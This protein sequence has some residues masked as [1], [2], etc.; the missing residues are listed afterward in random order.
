MKGKKEVRAGKIQFRVIEKDDRKILTGTPIVYNKNSED[1]GFIESIKPGASTEALKR[2]DPRLLYGHNSDTLLPLARKSAGTL[3]I[4]EDK[5][6]VHIEADPPD[7]QFARDMITSIERGDIQDMSFGFTI[8]DDKWETKDGRDHRTI[9][10]F[11]E[12]F[13]FSFVAFPAYPD[14]TVAMRSLEQ[15]KAD[16]AT[17]IRNGVIAKE[18]D[19]L[20]IFETEMRIKTGGLLKC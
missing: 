16:D 15:Y 20:L 10:E 14:T 5:S 2:S 3:K 11:D 8:K 18:Q 9:T 17:V 1:M 4:V 12:I 7:T 13:D 19:D 6:G